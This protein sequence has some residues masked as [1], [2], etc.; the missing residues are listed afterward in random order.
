MKK[1]FFYSLFFPDICNICYIC[2]FACF[3]FQKAG[4][5]IRKNKPLLTPTSVTAALC[6]VIDLRYWQ[7]LMGIWWMR[8]KKGAKKWNLEQICSMCTM[9]H[10]LF[11]SLRCFPTWTTWTNGSVDFLDYAKVIQSCRNQQQPQ[12]HGGRPSVWNAATIAR[13]K[14]NKKKTPHQKKPTVGL[15]GGGE[16]QQWEMLQR[17]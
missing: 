1:S 3:A 12:G 9:H 8:N 7:L 10:L 16:L 2:P 15:G 4:A 17:G 13:T 5:K 6:D 14:K 11:K